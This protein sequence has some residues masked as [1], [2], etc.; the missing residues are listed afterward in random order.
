MAKPVPG[1]PTI[2]ADMKVVLDGLKRISGRTANNL[3]FKMLGEL[4]EQTARVNGIVTRYY[5]I[6]GQRKVGGHKGAD[7]VSDKY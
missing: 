7:K 4:V 1:C 6:A 3:D 5:G 2:D